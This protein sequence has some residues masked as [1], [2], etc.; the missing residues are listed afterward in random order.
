MAQLY[1]FDKSG[2]AS[3]YG[4]GTYIQNL[5]SAEINSVTT[6]TVV[7]QKIGGD[8]KVCTWLNG[9][10]YITIPVLPPKSNHISID[11]FYT[12]E[13]V[14]LVSILQE[15]ISTEDSLIFH[16]NYPSDYFLAK[17]L[18]DRCPNSKI[19]Y[20]VHYHPWAIAHG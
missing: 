20:T 17:E 10:R 13:S 14:N 3:M 2:D 7:V 9:V 4:I 16:L 8:E 19:I 11:E 5:L 12:I 1:I 6:I 15:D 18:R